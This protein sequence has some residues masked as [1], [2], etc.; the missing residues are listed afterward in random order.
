MKKVILISGK[1]RSGK[2]QF[3]EYLQKELESRNLKVSTDLFAKDLKNWCKEDFKKLSYVLANIAEEI[4]SKINMWVD[5]RQLILGGDS[6]I[7][8]IES[9]INKLIIKDEN[10]YEDKT[11]ITRNILQLYGTEIFRNRV[12]E[13]WW[14]NQI[15]NRVISSDND[16]III[17]DCRFPNEIEGMYDENYETIVIRIIRNIN[18]PEYIA[19][20]DSETAL[21]N[22]QNWNYIVENNENLEILKNS[23]LNIVKDLFNNSKKDL[24][25]FT[26]M[27]KEE[28]KNLLKIC[29]Y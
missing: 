6:V 12:N 19:D 18:T 26:R 15:K 24:G 4:K 14:V 25:L 28:L 16:V 10:W 11:F 8:S 17:T 13:N 7:S 23:V 3:A 5:T 9:S 29:T 22:W 21:D 20:H 27:T 1:M 2:N